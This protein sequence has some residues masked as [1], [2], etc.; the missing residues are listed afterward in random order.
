VIRTFC[1]RCE[2]ET[3]GVT[4]GHVS[5]IPDADD[6]GNGEIQTSKDLCAR[7]YTEFRGW[8]K[9]P[10]TVKQARKPDP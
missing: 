10:R 4:S 7:C 9:L 3:T 6:N 1:D 8:L 2:A 5:G